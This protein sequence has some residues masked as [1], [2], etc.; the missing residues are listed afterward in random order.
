MNCYQ[1]ILL[2]KLRTPSLQSDCRRRQILET[3]SWR[4]VGDACATSDQVVLGM[5]E[6]PKT[7]A[8]PAS[9]SITL[10]HA[11]RAAVRPAARSRLC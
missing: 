7:E 2:L 3:L 5:T 6:E 4:I 8:A 10:I 9:L 1:R 11:M